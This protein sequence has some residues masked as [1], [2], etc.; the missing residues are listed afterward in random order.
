MLLNQSEGE[1]EIVEISILEPSPASGNPATKTAG[2]WHL[3]K[4]TALDTSSGQAMNVEKFDTDAAD[5]PSQVIA[6]AEPASVTLPGQIIRQIADAPG[7]TPTVSGGML[8]SMLPLQVTNNANSATIFRSGWATEVEPL[9]LREGE[10]VACV[11][12]LYGSP[13]AATVSM[14]VRVAG[15]GATYVIRSRDFGTRRAGNALYAV[16]N[17]VGSGVVL[18]VF[19]WMMMED[20]DTVIPG[21][22]LTRCDGYID[23][24]GSVELNTAI[25]N[26]PASPSLPS[27][28]KLVRGAALVKL[29]G[30]DMGVPY[31]W[32][33]GFVG[34][35]LTTT[36]VNGF[37]PATSP[38]G[39][40]TV[41]EQS[42]GT[43]RSV[44]R[45]A[46]PNDIG[47]TVGTP[48]IGNLFWK[49]K[50]GSGILLRKNQGV[51]IAAGRG[52]Y[53][54]SSQLNFYD[55]RVTFTYRPKIGASS[56]LA[57][58]IVRGA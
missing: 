52:G 17:G 49:A 4:I 31:R 33:E 36:N 30:W 16:F 44:S 37:V 27:D 18:E 45:V 11:Q 22:R 20:G 26:D 40:S 54:D 46:R 41:I 38:N 29:L 8:A 25:P 50:S 13:H 47:V 48:D 3:E 58:P 15:T 32:F 21:I 12:D 35:G 56:S 19:R 28:V 43:Y 9:V 23:V 42:I 51:A 14:M 5:L 34:A 6:W 2:T 1:I 53:V 24:A 39:M 55:I 7:L 10:G 57:N